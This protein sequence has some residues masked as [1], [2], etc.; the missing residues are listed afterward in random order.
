MVVAVTPRSPKSRLAAARMSSDGSPERVSRGR[1]LGRPI[2]P[3]LDMAAERRGVFRAC[4][5]SPFAC[6]GH[7]P[8]ADFRRTFETPGRTEVST[9]SLEG[10]RDHAR[11]QDGA[12]APTARTVPATLAVD[13]P[14]GVV[15][16]DVLWDETVG[17]GN[18]ASAALPAGSVVRLADPE[19]DAC[20]HL[21]VLSGRRSAE[22]LSVA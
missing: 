8:A 13:L 15:G 4:E 6:V 10:A 21:V 2:R 3:A 1:I 20:V 16:R 14:D 11:S 19:G 12:A 22:R 9:A 18:Y 5:T 7:A 17:A